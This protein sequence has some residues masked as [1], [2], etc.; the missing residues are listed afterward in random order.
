MKFGKRYQEDIEAAF[1][2]GMSAGLHMGYIAA[3]TR[4]KNY[5][6]SMDDMD[7]LLDELDQMDEALGDDE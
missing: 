1:D 3:E 2:E 5:I 7:W 4:I 6:A